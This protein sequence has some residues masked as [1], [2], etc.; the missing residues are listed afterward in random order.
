MKLPKNSTL[1]SV[2]NFKDFSSRVDIEGG[3]GKITL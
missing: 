1:K 3:L 2:D